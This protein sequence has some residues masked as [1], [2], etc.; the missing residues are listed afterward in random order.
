M[1]ASRTGRER[2]VQP[3]INNHSRPAAS[4][5]LSRQGQQFTSGQILL[6]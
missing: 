4:D 5:S 2:H 6:A 3:V 1:Y